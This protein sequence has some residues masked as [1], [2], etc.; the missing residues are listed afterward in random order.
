MARNKTDAV[1][2]GEVKETPVP[3]DG[4]DEAKE[5]PVP[6]DGADE[7]KE[8]PV[9]PDGADEAKENPVPPDGADAKQGAVGGIV[10]AQRLRLRSG[11]GLEHATLAELPCGT[12]F[13]VTHPAAEEDDWISVETAG[14][15]RGYVMAQYTAPTDTPED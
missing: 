7:A 1:G 10:R 4:A 3:P 13:V 12:A 2:A 9:P 15:M 6:P 8:T 11:P 5:T 14:G